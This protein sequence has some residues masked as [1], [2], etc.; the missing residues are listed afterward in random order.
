MIDR[1]LNAEGILKES[2]ILETEIKTG[3]EICQYFEIR[4]KWTDRTQAALQVWTSAL[5]V[6][7]FCFGIV[8]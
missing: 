2:I 4:I 3:C 7:C 8:C 5:E 1:V 6:S